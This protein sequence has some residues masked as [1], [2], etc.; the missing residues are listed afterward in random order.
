MRFLFG[1]LLFCILLSISWPL[2]VLVLVFMPIV[3][4]LAI[5]FV[6]VGI[7]IEAMF[8]LFRTML[9]LPARMLGARV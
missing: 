1:V 2:A 8:L 7:T 9:F 6:L 3:C 5:P 4:L